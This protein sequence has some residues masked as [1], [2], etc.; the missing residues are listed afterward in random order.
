MSRFFERSDVC[1][2]T[3]PA[4]DVF[5]LPQ[6]FK[7][8]PSAAAGYYIGITPLLGGRHT[9]HIHGKTPDGFVQDITYNLNVRRW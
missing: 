9:I 6:G 4:N 2:V 3:L 7:L 8:S 5:G 1:S